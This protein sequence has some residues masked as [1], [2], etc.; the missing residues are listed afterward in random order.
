MGICDFRLPACGEWYNNEDGSSRQEELARCVPGE[1]IKLVRE[2]DN[3]HDPAAVAVRSARGIKIGYLRRDRA[4]WIGSKI[5][6][7]YDVRGIVE[8]IKGAS[9][10]NSTLGLVMRLNMDGEDPALGPIKPDIGDYLLSH[11]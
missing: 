11:R 10:P 2:P 3:P 4:R 9:L 6:R 5:D 1:P 7:G 8:R